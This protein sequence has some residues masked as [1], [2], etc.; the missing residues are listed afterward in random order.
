[1]DNS[2]KVT[3][4]VYYAKLYSATL[5]MLKVSSWATNIKHKI[6]IATRTYDMLNKE[7]TTKR[8]ELLEII[9]ILLIAVEIVFFVYLELKH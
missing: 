3:D 2:L 7:I 8:S 5:S 9:I 1:V 6:E 4:D